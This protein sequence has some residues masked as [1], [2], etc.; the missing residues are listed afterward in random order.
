[1]NV[2]P[3]SKLCRNCFTSVT[4]ETDDSISSQAETNTSDPDYTVPIDQLQTNL[5]SSLVMA[6]CSPLIL[7]KYPKRQR[8]SYLSQKVQKLEAAYVSAVEPS[9]MLEPPSCASTAQT[10]CSDSQDLDILINELKK[11]CVLASKQQKIQLLTFAP[12]SWSFKKNS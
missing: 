9:A 5:N 11:K 10:N 7:S 1:M 12:P 8:S 6:G 4:D 2:K 3:G